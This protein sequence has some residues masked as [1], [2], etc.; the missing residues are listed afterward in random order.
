MHTMVRTQYGDELGYIEALPN[1]RYYYYCY[2][3]RMQGSRA[4]YIEAMEALRPYSIR[5]D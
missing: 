5:R 4:T 2:A 3:S 1:G